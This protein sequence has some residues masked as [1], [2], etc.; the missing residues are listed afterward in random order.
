MLFFGL[1]TSK[2]SYTSSRKIILSVM[3]IKQFE[4]IIL[5]YIGN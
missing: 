5:V 3:E 1:G 4:S 2:G